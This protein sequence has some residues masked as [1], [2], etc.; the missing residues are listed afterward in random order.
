[1]ERIRLQTANVGVVI[2]MDITKLSLEEFMCGDG[3]TIHESPPGVFEVSSEAV[4]P[5]VGQELRRLDDHYTVN[6]LQT[7]EGDVALLCD[8]DLVGY[9]CGPTIA[10]A[11]SHQKKDLSV[12]MILEAVKIGPRRQRGRTQQRGE[13]HCGKLGGWRMARNLTHGLKW[14]CAAPISQG[15]NS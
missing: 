14:E 2:Q 5:F 7:G 15:V 1:M 13:T 3:N 11:E 12:P 8:G 10:I 9:Y 4:R 6:E